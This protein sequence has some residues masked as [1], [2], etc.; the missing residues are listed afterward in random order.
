[1]REINADELKKIQLEILDAVNNFC[2]ENNIKFWLD[3][4]TLL[5]ADKVV[6]YESVEPKFT[7]SV[8]FDILALGEDHRGGRFDIVEQW[9]K[10]HGKKV[11]RLN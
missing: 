9:C 1:M 11:V 10:E 3:S 6:V 2:S 7:E 8:D 5:G 4:G